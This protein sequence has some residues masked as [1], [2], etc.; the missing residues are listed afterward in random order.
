MD[1]LLQLL[2]NPAWQGVGVVAAIALAF[3]TIYF[4]TTPRNRNWLFLSLGLVVII[5]GIIVG[6][7]L[8]KRA[9]VISETAVVR[10]KEATI[11]ALQATALIVAPT[12][13][14]VS[15]TINANDEGVPIESI[16]QQV[17]SFD[18]RDQ[19]KAGIGKLVIVWDEQNLYD[20]RLEYTMPSEEEAYA[21]IY[22]AFSPTEDLNRFN[23]I[24]TTISFSNSSAQCAIYLQDQ[25]GVQSYVRLTDAGTERTGKSVTFT[26]AAKGFTFIIPINENFTDVPINKGSIAGVGFGVNKDFTVG[27]HHCVIHD[28]R[29]LEQ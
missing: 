13:E 29:F 18:G 17:V 16:A 12:I 9:S 15:N 1:V 4:S 19:Q 3:I 28:L 7:E 14:A 11:E 23:S 6:A 21:G 8:Q 24:S 10:E 20:Y 22:F 2:S 5:I 26:P 25:N 27:E